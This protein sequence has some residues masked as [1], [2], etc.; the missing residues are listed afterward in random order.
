MYQKKNMSISTSIAEFQNLYLA[1][2]GM[3]LLLQCYTSNVL[4]MHAKA[5]ILEAYY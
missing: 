5:I 2:I 3:P 1:S 4:E